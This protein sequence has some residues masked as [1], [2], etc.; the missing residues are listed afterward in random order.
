[1]YNKYNKLNDIWNYDV[2]W[3]ICVGTC[4]FKRYLEHLVGINTNW[5]VRVNQ[6]NEISILKGQK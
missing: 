6:I 2:A 5:N 1:M 4:A 3:W